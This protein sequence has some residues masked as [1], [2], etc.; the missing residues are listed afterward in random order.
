MKK[1]RRMLILTG[2]TLI[3]VPRAYALNFYAQDY[4][5]H[6]YL[7]DN[8][9]MSSQ[10]IGN[11]QNDAATP[12]A[13]NRGM[14]M[15]YGPTGG[16]YVYRTR[17][18]RGQLS[19][20]YHYG[21]AWK[22]DASTVG[23]DSIGDA[24]EPSNENFGTFGFTNFPNYDGGFTFRNDGRFFTSSPVF[25]G[26]SSAGNQ[27]ALNDFDSGTPAEVFTKSNYWKYHGLEWYDDGSEQGKLFG[28]MSTSSGQLQLH[29]LN[30]DYATHGFSSSFVADSPFLST[31]PFGDLSIDGDILY[32]LT[33]GAS[34]S[35]LYSYNLAQDSGSFV[36]EGDFQLANLKSLAAL[37]GQNSVVPEPATLGL[38][39]LGLGGVLFKNRKRLLKW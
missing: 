18:Q 16:L 17:S 27:I 22:I 15:D 35:Q 8:G 39:T 12:A 38:L 20:L 19:R 25:S 4:D 29:L 2:I 7:L 31:M 11:V 32:I 23:N 30:L 6:L 14:A 26:S 37:P 24:T 10:M 5:G 36:F 9:T 1:I 21:E 33:S 34:A 13:L 28:L 3:C